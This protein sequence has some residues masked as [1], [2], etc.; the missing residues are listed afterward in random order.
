VPTRAARPYQGRAD[1]DPKGIG[2]GS[3]TRTSARLLQG[4]AGI[5][6][7]HPGTNWSP[8]QVPPLASRP[9]KGRPLVGA[10]GKYAR[11]D[12]NPQSHG[13]QPCP[14][15]CLRHE[16]MEPPARL[17]RAPAGYDAA[18]LPGELRRRCP[19]WIRTR[20]L[21]AS[22]AGVLP[23]ELEGIACARRDSNPQHAS[24]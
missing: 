24:F 19:P 7:T 16:R 8:R 10:G 21:A 11:R 6:S 4:Q 23:V 22:E 15:T 17:E 12:S 2:S 14:S 18:A 5:P 20:T 13:P 9:Y 1:A 3:W